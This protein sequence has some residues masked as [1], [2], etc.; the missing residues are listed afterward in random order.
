MAFGSPEQQKRFLPGIA[1]GEVWWSQ[2]YSEPGSGSDLASV[3]TRAERKGDK[4]IVNGQKTWTTLG[5]YGD[6]IFCLVRTSPP[7]A[8]RRPASPSC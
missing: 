6:W 8:S 2:G 7:K 5:Q 1:S 3:K 4:Y